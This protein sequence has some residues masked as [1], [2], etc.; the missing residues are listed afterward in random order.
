VADR[1]PQPGYLQS[2]LPLGL[3]IREFYMPFIFVSYELNS[4]IAVH[5]R[6]VSAIVPCAIVRI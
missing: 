5:E 2:T 3:S 4:A 6:Y 1:L